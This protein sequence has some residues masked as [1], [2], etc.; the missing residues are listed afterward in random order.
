[1]K[2]TSLSS[3]IILL[4]VVTAIL[5]TVSDSLTKLHQNYFQTH[6]EQL[7]YTTERTQFAD[8]FSESYDYYQTPYE[9][10]SQV[11]QVFYIISPL[12]LLIFL[13]AIHITR[14]KKSYKESLI[15][16]LS[17][18]IITYALQSYNIY[19]AVGWERPFGLALVS[20]YNLVVFV[21]VAV[22]NK[23]LLKSSY[24]HTRA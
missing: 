6:Q 18:V 23:I 24:S 21:I 22:I 16:P 13:S 5:F 10:A 1:M 7:R 20:I 2:F 19:S 17:F 14:D 15:I 8:G 12:I 11:T 3:K 9:R 4:A